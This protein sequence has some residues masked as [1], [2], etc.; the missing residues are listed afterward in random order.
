M[1]HGRAA[2]APVIA[3]DAQLDELNAVV[4]LALCTDKPR[5][6]GHGLLR[7]REH[8]ALRENDIAGDPGLCGI[9]CDGG[10]RIARGAQCDGRRFF[11][12]EL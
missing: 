12:T 6:V 5:A 3:V 1:Q 7:A 9:G 2:V 8:A 11:C 4:D 10:T